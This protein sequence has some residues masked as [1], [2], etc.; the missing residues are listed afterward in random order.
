MQYNFI[1]TRIH[2]INCEV[3]Y[4]LTEPTEVRAE[5]MFCHLESVTCLLPYVTLAPTVP[6]APPHKLS[7]IGFAY[8]TIFPR[9]PSVLLS[10]I[11]PVF[12][13]SLAVVVSHLLRGSLWDHSL[14]P[15]LLPSL[16]RLL[17]LQL[18]LLVC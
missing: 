7:P 1:Q 11:L 2:G 5:G 3:L 16:T 13:R 8:S 14:L 15:R 6:L 9:V 17:L 4:R 12:L 18:L 10:L